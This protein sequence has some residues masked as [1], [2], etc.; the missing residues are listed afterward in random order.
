MQYETLY[1]C[2][3]LRTSRITDSKSFGGELSL[4]ICGTRA[5]HRGYGRV[6]S[7]GDVSMMKSVLYTIRDKPGIL[8]NETIDAVLV[9][10]I[11][12]QPTSVIF[13]DDG[14]YQLVSNLRVIKL[15]DTKKKWSALSLYGVWQVFVLQDSLR[16]RSIN[17][18]KLPDWVK[19][20]DVSELQQRLH[21]AH[22]V[23]SD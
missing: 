17:P 22:F 10:G 6:R 3:C 9:S 7:F 20:I 16:E 19:P 21:S 14:V 12:D 8:A 2:S 18:S 11:M 13:L 23:I 4:P 1:L 5:T 15:K